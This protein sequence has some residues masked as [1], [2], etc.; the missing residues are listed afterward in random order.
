M[1]EVERNDFEQEQASREL[2]AAIVAQAR[3][4]GPVELFACWDGDEQGPALA[5]EEHATADWIVSALEPFAERTAHR[6][7]AR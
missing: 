1:S 4:G 7:L 6:I 2:L 3:S 5:A